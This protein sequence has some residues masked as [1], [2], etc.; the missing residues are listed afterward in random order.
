[1]GLLGAGLAGCTPMLTGEMATAG[2]NAA[3]GSLGNVLGSA[4]DKKTATGED[5]RQQKIQSVLNKAEVGQDVQPIV[6][7]IEE[8]PKEKSANAYGFTCYEYPAVYSGTEAAVIVA[9]SGKIVFF[10]NSRCAT[11]M[12]ASNFVDK[13]KYS[14]MQTSESHA[15]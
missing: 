5:P 8:Q 12:L 7:L 4:D 14:R 3:K 6:E 13:G 11:E 1:M 15:D 2:Y 10:G 9:K